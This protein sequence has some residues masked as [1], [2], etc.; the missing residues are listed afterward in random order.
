M[1][2]L[3]DL[4]CV[5]GGRT[6]FSALNLSV[7][8]GR[9]LHVTG[10]NGAGK[11]SLLRMVCG[12]LSPMRGEVLWR[13][14]PIAKLREDFHRQLVFLGHLAALKDDLTAA[15]NLLAGAR[16]AGANPEPAQVVA[17]LHGAGLQGHEH[18][19]ARCLSQGQ[20]RRVAL[21]RLVLAGDAALWVLDEPFNALDAPASAWLGRLVGGHVDRG[22]V[23]LVTS[24][25]AALGVP[26]ATQPLE[27]S[28]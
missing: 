14:A 27:L 11:T 12:L 3:R 19:P 2:E 24:H 26:C 7:P 25:Q 17:A 10:A 6:L 4:G 8:G 13:G 5:R 9:L 23:V 28:L 15:E 1:L 16:M 18:T 20:R 22:G 21:A